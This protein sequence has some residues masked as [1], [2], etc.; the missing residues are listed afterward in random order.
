MVMPGQVF[1]N[2]TACLRSFSA[3]TRISAAFLRSASDNMRPIPSSLAR[4][5]LAQLDGRE[6]A[7]GAGRLLAGGAQHDGLDRALRTSRA[8][9]PLALQPKRGI[10]LLGGA[11]V[12]WPAVG[13]ALV[14]ASIGR[15]A[16][17][18]GGAVAG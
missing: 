6:R 9:L 2:C 13:K 4:K 7:C 1:D 8:L 17:A 18:I 16:C 15:R 3:A 5:G 10:A 14:L 12:E 11:Y